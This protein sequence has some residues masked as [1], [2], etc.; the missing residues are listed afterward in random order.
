MAAT[1]PESST[2][3]NLNTKN[4]LLFNEFINI[5]K[6]GYKSADDEDTFG[7]ETMSYRSGSCDG[8]NNHNFDNIDMFTL[9]KMSFERARIFAENKEICYNTFLEKD[10]EFEVDSEFST[11]LELTSTLTCNE[12][13]E[14][15]DDN[16]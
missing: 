3:K 16:S 1:I 10:D 14:L 13:I 7:D 9:D 15:E 4:A 6:F 11:E 8:S 5:N 2:S 12:S